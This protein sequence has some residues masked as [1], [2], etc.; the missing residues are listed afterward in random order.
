MSKIKSEKNVTSKVCHCYF[1]QKANRN[2]RQ[3]LRITRH[4]ETDVETMTAAHNNDKFSRRQFVHLLILNIVHPFT[5]IAAFC[6]WSK[7]VRVKKTHSDQYASVP[8]HGGML[9]PFH[10]VIGLVE[11]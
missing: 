6:M 11:L 7:N 2:Q 5:L 1:G 8:K 4:L 3:F 10:P 9:F